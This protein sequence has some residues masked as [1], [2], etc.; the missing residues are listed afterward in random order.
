M[1]KSEGKIGDGHAAAM[2]RMGLAELRSALYPESNVA[3]PSAEYGVFGKPTPGETADAREAQ[4]DE[5]S[6]L[7]E[8]RAKQAEAVG[9]QRELSRDEEPKR[10]PERD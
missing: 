7:V 5:K 8:D 6:S 10:E 3:Q 2:G 1:N 9:W 4:A